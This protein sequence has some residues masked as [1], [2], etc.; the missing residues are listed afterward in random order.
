MDA[1]GSDTQSPALGEPIVTGDEVAYFR[2]NGFVV[3]RNGLPDEIRPGLCAVVEGVLRDN[4][5]WPNLLRMPHVPKRPGLLE[6]VVGGDHVFRYAVHPALLNI[7]RSICGPDVIMWGSEIFAKPAGTGKATPWHQDNYT[8]AVRA[9]AAGARS[10]A[11]SIWIA[12]DDVGLDNGCLRF[13]PGSGKGG[14]L[15]HSKVEAAG[16]LLNF[17]VEER[18]FDEASAVD[19][20][21]PSGHFSIHDSYVLHGAKANT[22]GRRRAALTLHY[23]AATDVY[24]R[25]F[26]MAK[27]SGLN[28]PAP[29]ALRPIW[30]VLGENRNPANDFTVG[31]DGLADLD[32]WAEEARRR[33][34]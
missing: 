15:P 25:S 13:V 16:S 10:S 31:H 21:L 8:P 20:I 30:L 18:N 34:S 3:P 32:G 2:E 17:N 22:S 27:G 12:I 4:A 23:M 24:D 26:G 9:T 33:Y 28:K 6:G 29:I 14:N 1:S 19:A 7:A 5:D 11:I